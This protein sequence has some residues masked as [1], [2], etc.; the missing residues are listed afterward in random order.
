[1]SRVATSSLQNQIL[2]HVVNNTADYARLQEQI[3]TGK[4]AQQ[5]SGLGDLAG[6]QIDLSAQVRAYDQYTENSQTASSRLD[7]QATALDTLFDIASD[8][9]TKVMQALS[10]TTGNQGQVTTLANTAIDT[11]AAALNS[12]LGGVYVFGGIG[13]DQPPV[14]VS[15]RSVLAPLAAGEA[16]PEKPLYY[17]GSTE[18]SQARIDDTETLNYGL[19]AND[20]AFD[21]LMRALNL[22][23]T[24]GGDEDKL[25]QANSMLADAITGIA[26]NQAVVGNQQK[27]IE[28]IQSRQ[29]EF[30]LTLKT[31][32]GTIQDVDP[33][34]AM[35]E[36]TKVQTV[37]QAS[38]M[39]L[40][41]VSQLSLLNSIR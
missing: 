27:Q 10:G 6:Q 34:L 41:R 25:N 32:L 29:S 40:S 9:R 21:K 33:S 3:T 8:M 2:N 19:T 12:S 23:A 39:A 18:Q 4:K 17:N 14:D 28:D 5:Y 38:Y 16:T 26:D 30:K 22:V 13:G 1:M 15:D 31:Q 35:V 37:L 7:T 11:V 20:P 36:L 24:S